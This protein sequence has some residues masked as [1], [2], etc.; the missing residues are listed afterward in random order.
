MCDGA[1]RLDQA[2]FNRIDAEIGKRLA[3]VQ[4]LSPRQVVLGAKLVNKYRRQLGESAVE[5]IRDLLGKGTNEKRE[6][7]VE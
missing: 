7:S 2:G 4:H 3:Y 5:S 1:R 6:C